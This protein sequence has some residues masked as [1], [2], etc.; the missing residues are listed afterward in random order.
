MI[1]QCV[2]MMNPLSIPIV[3]RAF[4]LARSGE[5]TRLRE[6]GTQLAGEGYLDVQEHLQDSRLLRQQLRTLVRRAAAG[7]IEETEVG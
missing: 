3:E 7:R 4:Q 2:G 5:F 6:I 1:E